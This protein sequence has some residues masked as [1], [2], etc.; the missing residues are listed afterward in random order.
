[1]NRLTIFW[2]LLAL[3]PRKFREQFSDEML[4]V[5]QQKIDER[6]GFRENVVCALI[7]GEYFCL[8]KGATSGP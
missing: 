2:A 1:M 3:Y 6:T 7:C 5:F 4:S 8:L